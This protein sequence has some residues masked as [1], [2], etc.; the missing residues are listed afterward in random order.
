[1]W[2][3]V[4]HGD[5]THTENATVPNHCL[6]MCTDQGALALRERDPGENWLEE[7]IFPRSLV[8]CCFGGSPLSSS[9]N[10]LQKMF[11]LTVL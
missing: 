7:S 9:R 10:C 8:L 4:C 6:T 1:M 2:I 3:S 11:S 5:C